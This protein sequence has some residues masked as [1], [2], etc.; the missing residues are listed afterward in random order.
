MNF[1]KGNSLMF[2]NV[3]PY[4]LIVTFQ[5]WQLCYTGNEVFYAVTY[6]YLRTFNI[7]YAYFHLTCTMMSIQSLMEYFSYIFLTKIWRCMTFHMLYNILVKDISWKGIFFK[8][9]HIWY[10]YIKNVSHIYGTVSF[11]LV[12]NHPFI[13]Y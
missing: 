1:Q 7:I 12:S 8:F 3:F 9:S 10:Q 4:F 6:F 11:H 5:I 2:L 13:K